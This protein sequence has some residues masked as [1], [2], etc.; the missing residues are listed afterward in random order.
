MLQVYHWVS[1]SSTQSSDNLHAYPTQPL[2]DLG[3]IV[4]HNWFIGPFL[5]IIDNYVQ[6]ASIPVLTHSI[7]FIKVNFFGLWLHWQDSWRHDRETGWERGEWHVAQCPRL[8]LEPGDTAARTKPALPT[9]LNCTSD[10]Q[11]FTSTGLSFRKLLFMS[12]LKLE[13]N[14]LI[15]SHK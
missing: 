7:P 6:Y 15:T 1:Q 12:R 11:Y 9:E 10:T 13:V 8:G 4:D 2:L 5:T 14:C 3:L